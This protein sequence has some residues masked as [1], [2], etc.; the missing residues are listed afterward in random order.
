M[1]IDIKRSIDISGISKSELSKM[2]GISYPTMLS[3]YNGEATSIRF[4]TLEKLCLIFNC[5]PD[6]ILKFEV[7]NN[8]IEKEGTNVFGFP[9]IN[10]LKKRT[11]NFDKLLDHATLDLKIEKDSDGNII[12]IPIYK[13]KKEHEKNN[14][15]HE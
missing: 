5:T 7:D 9:Y 11:E 3:I 1:K 15:S 13:L 14:D 6:E 12:A 8:Y 2:L 10:Q 4:D